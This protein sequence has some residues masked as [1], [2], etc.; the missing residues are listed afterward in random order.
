MTTHAQQKS[1]VSSTHALI[2]AWTIAGMYYLFF[3]NLGPFSDEG[4]YCTIGQGIVD[5][6]LPY[7]DYFNEKPPLQYYW[8]ALIFSL[9]GTGIDGSRIASS[10]MLGLALSLSLS[11]LTARLVSFVPLFFWACMLTAVGFIMQAYNN[12]AESSLAMLF[13]ASLILVCK[14]GI[15]SPTTTSFATGFLQGLAC[16]FRITSLISALVLLIA[17]WHRASRWVYFSGLLSGLTL[18]IGLIGSF[19]IL[20][21]MLEATVLFH[22]DNPTASTYLRWMSPNGLKAFSLWMLF[23]AGASIHAYQAKRSWMVAWFI[24]AALPFFGRMDAFRLWPATL[25]CITYLFSC[26]CIGRNKVNLVLYGLAGL[27][28]VFSI[29]RPSTFKDLDEIANQVVA[30]TSS[31]DTIWVGPYMPYIYCLSNRR[32]A[33]RYYF[34]LPWTTKPLAQNQLI[35]DLHRNQ[36]KLILDASNRQFSLNKLTPEISQI[37]KDDYTLASDID[38][39]KIY[40][41][42]P[43]KQNSSLSADEYRNK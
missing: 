18:W 33:S 15:F 19:G 34:V 28:T 11:Q 12:L 25:L 41:R 1:R 22:L 3:R 14:P 36:P 29:N 40:L 24:I 26:N 5:G 2:A 39:I 30:L 7:K 23:L 17:P 4:S 32:P 9:F 16:G 37:I 35:E 27:I 38:E 21:E 6:Y 10:I 13:V 43:Q 20:S 8:T 31:Y 42:K